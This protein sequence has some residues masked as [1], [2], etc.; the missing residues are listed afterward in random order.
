MLCI[1]VC[2]D[3]WIGKRAVEVLGFHYNKTPSKTVKFVFMLL[4]KN[5]M[6]NNKENDPDRYQNYLDILH[7][8]K[9]LFKW[10]EPW[11]LPKH[12]DENGGTP[13]LNS[14]YGKLFKGKKPQLKKVYELSSWDS[15]CP[16]NEKPPVHFLPEFHNKKLTIQQI[17]PI[18]D[19]KNF[20]PFTSVRLGPF[21]KQG[22]HLITFSLDLVGDTYE[23]L[24]TK[25]PTFPIDGPPILLQRIH[26]NYFNR[27]YINEDVRAIYDTEFKKFENFLFLND[28][29]DIVII[30]DPKKVDQVNIKVDGNSAEAPIQLHENAKTIRYIT[31]NPNFALSVRYSDNEIV[32]EIKESNQKNFD[33]YMLEIKKVLAQV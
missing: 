8:G 11:P 21:C 17:S 22:Y 25:K 33:R 27:Q 15:W 24:V 1:A 20:E 26:D 14:I 12:P 13:A 19:D 30:N 4:I 9:V 28:S 7:P 10:L 29:Y 23:E 5:E 6:D 32:E 2:G 18:Q 16:V 3:N 31:R